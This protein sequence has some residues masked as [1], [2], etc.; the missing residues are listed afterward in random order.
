MVAVPQQRRGTLSNG[1][2]A[3]LSVFAS[4]LHA[5]RW[6]GSSASWQ[7]VK[8]CPATLLTPVKACPEVQKP[9]HNAERCKDQRCHRAVVI[10]ACANLRLFSSQ[11]LAS[12]TSEGIPKRA[13]RPAVCT[14]LQHSSLTCAYD[15]MQRGTGCRGWCRSRHSNASFSHLATPRCAVRQAAAATVEHDRQMKN[16][17]NGATHRAVRTGDW[18][19]PG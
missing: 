17:E 14:Q 18:P 9:A 16:K 8:L 3:I 6:D 5:R 13:G 15:S 4:Q 2:A 19:A 12:H 11:W 7:Y 10:K 1:E